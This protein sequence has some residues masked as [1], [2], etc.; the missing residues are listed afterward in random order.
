MYRCFL[1]HPPVTMIS[2][3]P[4]C[5][6]LFWSANWMEAIKMPLS[7]VGL[8]PRSHQTFRLVLAVNLPGIMVRNRRWPTTFLTI[9][10]EDVDGG[11]RTAR[12]DRPLKQIPLS[13][14]LSCNGHPNLTK[15]HFPIPKY[16]WASSL[17]LNGRTPYTQDNIWKVKLAYKHP[18][19]LA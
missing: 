4:P 2:R 13:L 15:P 1:R 17:S 11:C 18:R 8:M 6:G 5:S 14:S 10:A 3:P 16:V 9:T 7:R 12:C 19:K